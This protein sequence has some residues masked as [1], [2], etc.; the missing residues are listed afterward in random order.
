MSDQQFQDRILER[1]ELMDKHA[2]ERHQDTLEA[3]NKL[4]KIVTGGDDPSKGIVVKLDR[5]HQ[6]QISRDKW[7]FGIGV[8][9]TAA[10]VKSFGAWI[11]SAFQNGG[12]H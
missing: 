11:V 8:A 10:L 12:G 7:T 1:L 4:N 6:S 9:A 5:L 2:S 3:V